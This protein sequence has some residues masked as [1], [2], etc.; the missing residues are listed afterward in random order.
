V[1]LPEPAPG[2]VIRYSY[3]WREEHLK[4]QE[5]GVKDRPCAIILA[6]TNE[7]D[8]QIV[9]VLPITHAVPR[10]TG[11]AIARSREQSHF[12]AALQKN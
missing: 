5:E 2:L 8:D 12:S 10:H 4:G 9:T 6:V 3:L 11:D 1:P 7:N